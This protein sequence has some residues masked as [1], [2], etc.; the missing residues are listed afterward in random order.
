MFR[1]AKLHFSRE[2][3]VKRKER[4][5]F[6]GKKPSAPAAV[7]RP[8]SAPERF[9]LIPKGEGKSPWS[10]TTNGGENFQE[11]SCE[12]CFS[13]KLFAP[14]FA[15][16]FPRPRGRK[17]CYR[18]S[19]TPPQPVLLRHKNSKKTLGNQRKM[20]SASPP[21]L[22]QTYSPE[23]PAKTASATPP[24]KKK[25]VQNGKLFFRSRPES[26]PEKETARSSP[27]PPDKGRLP[28]IPTSQIHSPHVHRQ[29]LH[30]QARRLHR[31]FL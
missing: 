15:R 28:L 24:G 4:V 18:T 21:G 5:R 6:F 25:V 7:G 16:S 17:P 1:A 22:S 10:D 3:R 14:I 2:P 8:R 26:F 20:I 13:G 31:A 12:K 23:R 30:H 29:F 9:A 27:A 19:G 11:K